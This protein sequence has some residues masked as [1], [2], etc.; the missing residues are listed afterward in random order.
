MFDE[1]NQEA[2]DSIERAVQRLLL[3]FRNSQLLIDILAAL[4]G[5][6][7]TLIDA[8][9]DVINLRGPASAKGEQLDGIGHIVGQL[10]SVVDFD[11]IA[12]F[13]PDRL[14][15]GVDQAPVWVTNA[16]LAGSLVA[17]DTW[18]RQLIEAKVAR[19][20]VRWGSVP[21]IQ[22]FIQYAFGI[23]VS[24]ITVDTMTVQVVVP[25]NTSY[26][27]F[28]ALGN[29]VQNELVENPYFLPFAAGVQV[30]EVVRLSQ[31]QDSSG[32]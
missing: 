29:F 15:Q 32:S 30:S 5:E 19:N 27:V 21:E 13:S 6:V 7:Q 23:D 12:W 31:V 28:E 14:Y 20:F 8:T 26:N 10:R 4:I 16:P 9:V 2:T 24:F 11:A 25:D 18:Y 1:I 22:N 3:Q 17:D